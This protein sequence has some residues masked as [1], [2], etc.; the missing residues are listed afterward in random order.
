[1]APIFIGCAGGVGGAGGAGGAGGVG[2]QAAIKGMTASIKIR[3]NPPTSAKTFF[4]NINPPFRFLSAKDHYTTSFITYHPLLHDSSPSKNSKFFLL[5]PNLLY[6]TTPSMT[7]GASQHP[8]VLFTFISLFS[9]SCN[10]IFLTGQSTGNSFRFRQTVQTHLSGRHALQANQ[11][12]FSGCVFTLV[13]PTSLRFAI[14]SPKASIVFH[15]LFNK[16]LL[17]NYCSLHQ[18]LSYRYFVGVH[19]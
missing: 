9:I 8:T 15:S 2:A 1:M 12:D 7:F 10:T 17:F 11:I 16:S 19:S 18:S 3:H 4:M 6:A 5:L 14:E 13:S